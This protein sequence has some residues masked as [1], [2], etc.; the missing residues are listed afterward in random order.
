MQPSSGLKRK[1]L[2]SDLDERLLAAIF[3]LQCRHL[4]LGAAS[5]LVFLV[6]RHF[7]GRVGLGFSC[8]ALCPG[9]VRSQL[10]LVAAACST[11]STALCAHGLV[12][13]PPTAAFALVWCH[14]G[15]FGCFFR[16]ADE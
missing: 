9:E 10:C 15:S 2:I 13:S 6:V 8:S 16:T 3:A 5:P 7:V 4:N 12:M 14:L 1:F 11:P